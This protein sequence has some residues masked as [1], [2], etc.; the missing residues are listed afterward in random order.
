M[1][2]ITKFVMYNCF[3]RPGV[4]Y[5]GFEIYSC[6][7]IIYAESDK[8]RHSLSPEIP[9]KHRITSPAIRVTVRLSTTGTRIESG[10]RR[11]DYNSNSPTR[12]AVDCRVEDWKAANFPLAFPVHSPQFNSRFITV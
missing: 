3:H 5:G 6:K 8:W 11:M 9:S 7:T 4:V 1:R 12:N 2:K 10:N